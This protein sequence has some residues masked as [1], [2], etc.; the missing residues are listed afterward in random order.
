MKSKERIKSYRQILVDFCNAQTSDEACLTLFRNLQNLFSFSSNFAEKMEE[1]YPS[2]KKLYSCFNETER[3]LFDLVLEGERLKWR[4]NSELSIHD[5]ISLYFYPDSNQLI[6]RLH[7]SSEY[8]NPI[9][10]DFSL[11]KDID[12]FRTKFI[13]DYGYNYRKFKKLIEK[14]IDVSK[15]IQNFNLIPQDD[16][17]KEFNRFCGLHEITIGL[18]VK[19][20]EFQR[21]IRDI[22][23]SALKNKNLK[24]FKGILE[25]YNTLHTTKLKI[26]QDTIVDEVPVMTETERISNGWFERIEYY[27]AYLIGEI[28]KIDGGMK[29]IGKCLECKKYFSRS[30]LNEKK[31]CSDKCRL[32]LNNRRRIESGEHAEYKRQKRKKGA[33][34]SDSG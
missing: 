13:S 33:R 7:D 20:E 18:H 10:Y 25:K 22:L 4:L 8:G 11:P 21:Y 29:Y 34:T 26:T 16:K 19:V 12:L 6:L 1:N 27:L 24:P 31:Y 30:R 23:E 15:R 5:R 9:Y 14:L 3:E 17:T 32:T 28:L 2:L